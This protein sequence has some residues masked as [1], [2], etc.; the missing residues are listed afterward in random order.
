MTAASD[1]CEAAG[2]ALRGGSDVILAFGSLSYL[3]D[4]KSAIL[5]RNEEMSHV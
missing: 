2:L 5:K 1:F 4:I 3:R